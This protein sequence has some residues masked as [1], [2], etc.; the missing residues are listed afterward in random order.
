MKTLKTLKHI[1]FSFAFVLALGLM[2][3]DGTEAKAAVTTVTKTDISTPEI[4]YVGYSISVTGSNIKINNKAVKKS[5][6]KV[7]AI[8]TDEDPTYYYIPASYVDSREYYN[9]AADYEKAQNS[10]SYK[11]A[12]SY[13]FVF[14]KAGTYTFS[15]DSY[16]YEIDYVQVPGK[17]YYVRNVT[18]E[19]TTHVRKIKVLKDG[20]VLKS[21]QLGKA[22]VTNKASYGEASDSYK[23]VSNKY[24]TGT[25]GKLNIKLN[26]NYAITSIL[27]MT[28]DKEGNQVYQQVNNKSTVTYGDYLYDTTTYN[29]ETGVDMNKKNFVKSL[30]KKTVVFIGYRNKFT[31][32]YSKYTI[33]TDAQGEKYIEAEYLYAGKDYEGNPNTVQK[34]EIR[35]GQSLYNNGRWNDGHAY[36]YE[37]GPCTCV[38]EFKKK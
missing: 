6:K 30:M 23:T 21:I 16:D 5:K 3:S 17:T 24:L 31:G 9:T 10:Y 18:V 14:K 15:W 32:D 37:Y 35:S 1:I 8:L 36:T 13:T 33:K 2:L 22:K 12:K 11:A 26:S 27:V 19:K 34:E 29:V 25:S 7:R 38:V 28:Y 4:N 20:N